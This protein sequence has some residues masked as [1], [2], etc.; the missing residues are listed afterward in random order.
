MD[1]ILFNILQ[2]CRFDTLHS[3]YCHKTLQICRCSQYQFS[4][5]RHVGIDEERTKDIGVTFL[6][7]FFLTV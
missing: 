6:L 5:G 7:M 1:I 2:I 3:I 4:Q